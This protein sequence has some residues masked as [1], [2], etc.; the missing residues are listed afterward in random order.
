MKHI[1]HAVIKCPCTTTNGEKAECTYSV[2]LYPDM[3]YKV[4][5]CGQI[6]GK[7][8]LELPEY[9]TWTIFGLLEGKLREV[10]QE[11]TKEE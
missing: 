3:T 1:F 10:I 5:W 6:M 9:G 2:S 8:T 4:R 7:G 11:R